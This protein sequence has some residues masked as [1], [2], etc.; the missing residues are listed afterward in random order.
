MSSPL[1]AST[2]AT[3]AGSSVYFGLERIT[4]AE[5][6]YWQT[7]RV[8]AKF[9]SKAIIRAKYGGIQRG[10][11][12]FMLFCGTGVGCAGFAIKNR[13][14]KSEGYDYY[15]AYAST[16]PVVA[17]HRCQ[18]DSSLLFRS[19]EDVDNIEMKEA[20]FREKYG[21]L[22]MTVG[23][24][25]WDR[26]RAFENRG[27]FRNPISSLDASHPGISLYLHAFAATAM[28]QLSDH[29]LDYLF[30]NASTNMA[31]NL[32][33]KKLAH[34]I[35]S[36]VTYPFTPLS[37]TNKGDNLDLGDEQSESDVQHFENVKNELFA[38]AKVENAVLPTNGYLF[39]PQFE[40]SPSSDIPMLLSIQSLVD[41]FSAV[42]VVPRDQDAR[43]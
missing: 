30:V 42:E 19:K 10:C 9:L 15:V 16:T 4:P 18:Q 22:L 28:Q 2:E 41:V 29:P 14:P 8:Q 17:P 35:A 13:V 1:V 33:E 23:V 12:R 26:F 5:A 40:G 31:E 39:I 6:E 3:I 37:E 11:K 24:S 27:I 25:R 20:A 43:G 38:C 34:K 7:Y 32:W 21:T 36:P